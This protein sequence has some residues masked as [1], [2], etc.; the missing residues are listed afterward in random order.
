M[1]IFDPTSCAGRGEAHKTA[2]D[3]NHVM[4]SAG[5]CMFG[6]LCLDANH[7]HEFLN[8]VTG[9]NHTFD[10]VFK[11]G[12]RIGNIRQAFNIREG[13]TT[14]DFKIP[15][16]ILGC[17]PLADGPNAGKEVDLATLRR[18]YFIAMDWD[19]ESGKPSKA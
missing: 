6:Y 3:L 19:S 11:I 18:E 8:L 5:L 15:D 2:C 12:E 14:K 9:S 17:P 4:Q 7:V 13:I 10:D 16:R 1:A